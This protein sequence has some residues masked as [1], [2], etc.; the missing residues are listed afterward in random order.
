MKDSWFISLSN[1]PSNELLMWVY[2]VV[3]ESL[4]D[5]S[6]AAE[7]LFTSNKSS[8]LPRTISREQHMKSALEVVKAKSF[9]TDIEWIKYDGT[10]AKEHNRLYSLLNREIYRRS[11]DGS[12]FT[13]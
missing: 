3:A 12:T 11:Q 4:V 10:S 5:A 9:C 8:S 1:L 6:P 13:W 7:L 2:D